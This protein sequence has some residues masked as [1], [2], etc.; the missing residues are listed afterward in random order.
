MYTHL[1][2]LS[3]QSV[4]TQSIWKWLNIFLTVGLYG[5]EL[6]IGSGSTAEGGWKED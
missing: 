6:L 5:I 4:W 1:L 3:S 2:L